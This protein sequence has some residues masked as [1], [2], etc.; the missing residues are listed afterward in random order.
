M[1]LTAEPLLGKY[2]AKDEDS[3][4]YIFEVEPTIKSGVWDSEVGGLCELGSLS[5]L[6]PDIPRREMGKIPWKE[7]LH[8][9][10]LHGVLRPLYSPPVPENDQLVWVR[11]HHSYDWELRYSVGKLDD[12]GRLQAWDAGRTSKTAGGIKNFWRLWKPYEEE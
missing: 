12:E 4:W 11:D 5:F 1:R 3:I 10:G 2:V 6:I 8:K 7:S 9:I